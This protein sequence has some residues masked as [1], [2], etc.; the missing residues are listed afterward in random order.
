MT[1]SIL[2]VDLSLG[3]SQTISWD[4]V[5]WK[6]HWCYKA[7]MVSNRMVSHWLLAKGFRFL[8]CRPLYRVKFP[9]HKQGTSSQ[10]MI[11]KGRGQSSV[12]CCM[13]YNPILGVT[14]HHSICILLMTKTNPG[15]TR[16][17][18][19]NLRDHLPQKFT[20]KSCFW[21]HNYFLGSFSFLDP[22]RF[23]IKC[24]IIKNINVA[25]F[26]YFYIVYRC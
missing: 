15:E 23:G 17:E 24:R 25:I 11:P 20:P 12:V 2:G 22:G 8:Q 18:I 19:I 16:K 21:S 13:F 4:S 5:I 7:H 26:L 1:T 14:Y 6:L 10:W 3:W 9:I